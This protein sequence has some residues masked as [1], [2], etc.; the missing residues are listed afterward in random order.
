MV[1]Y[2]ELATNFLILGPPSPAGLFFYKSSPSRIR[3]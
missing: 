2:I 3:A 1:A